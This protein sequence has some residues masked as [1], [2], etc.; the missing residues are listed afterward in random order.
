[1]SSKLPA[2]DYAFK[3]LLGGAGGTGKSTFVRVYMDGI[4]VPDMKL[5]V[6]VEFHVKNF[7][8]NNKKIQFVIWDLGG[9]DRFKF[10]HE[11]YIKGSRAGLVFFDMSHLNTLGQVR[12]W[13]ALFR[14]YTSPDLPMI[15][16]GAK[17]DL[18]D[19]VMQSGIDAAA[20]L[21]VD[22]LQLLAYVVTSSKINI[23]VNETFDFLKDL[24]LK[25]AKSG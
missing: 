16:V 2:P 14:K 10:L 6:G 7:E 5:T 18:V 3:I 24:F 11:R 21:V 20:Q 12:D 4:F 8:I 15:L 1:M 9:Q 25:K 13:V 17:Q 22:E 23:N 19:P